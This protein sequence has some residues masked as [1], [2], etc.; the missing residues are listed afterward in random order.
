L[1]S[2][3]KTWVLAFPVSLFIEPQK[4]AQLLAQRAFGPVEAWE[5]QTAQEKWPRIEPQ[6]TKETLNL[7]HHTY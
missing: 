1:I 5:G 2:L 3:L 7:C 4:V 6:M